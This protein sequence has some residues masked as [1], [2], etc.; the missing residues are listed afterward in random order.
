MV[1][2]PFVNESFGN[3]SGVWPFCDLSCVEGQ[4][5]KIRRNSPTTFIVFAISISL[6]AAALSSKDAKVAY[7]QGDYATAL[8]IWSS[9]A[10]QASAEAQERLGA[11]YRDGKGVSQDY[12]ASVEWFRKAADQGDGKAENNLGA[13]YARGHGVAKNDAQAVNWFRKAADHGNALGQTNLGRMYT[14]GR[15][16]PKDDAESVEWFRLAAEQG[17][18]AA[19]TNRAWMYA[20]G[21]GV[22][23]DENEAV[24]WYRKAAE[25]GFASAQDNLG[26]MYRDGRSVTQ[27]FAV[28]VE[29]FRKAAEQGYAEGE[30]NLGYMYS[31]G[32]GVA[33]DYAEAMKWYRKAAD[34]GE[35]HAQTNLGYMYA[36]GHG[37]SKDDAEAVLW[38]RKAAEQG[39]ARAQ[40][41]LAYMYLQ[42]HG[43]PK[44]EAEA[45]SLYRKAAEQGLPQ[46]QNGLGVMYRDGRGL[47]QDYVAAIEWFR[48]AGEQG[49]ASAQINLGLMYRD[50]Q[51]VTKDDAAATQWLQKAAEQGDKR[52]KSMLTSIETRGQDSANLGSIVAELVK[53]YEDGQPQVLNPDAERVA[54]ASQLIDALE[55]RKRLANLPEGFDQVDSPARIAKVSPKLIEAIRLTAV[56]SFRPEKLVKSLDKKLAQTLDTPTLQ[57]GLDWERSDLGRRINALELEAERLEHRAAKKEFVQQ[58][59][60]K[61]RAADDARGRACGEKLIL[62][63]SP[64]ALLP[65][66]EALAAAGAMAIA[67]QQEQP[68]DMRGIEGAMLIVRPTL[69]DVAR[70]AM[71]AE[72][73]FSLQDLS[74]AEF[75]RLLGFLHTESGGRYARGANAAQ[76]D[77]F[78]DATEVFARTL[79]DVARKLRANR[80]S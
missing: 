65:L 64:D 19:Q 63:N 15:G 66:M 33:Q 76:R 47:A 5:M 13:M 17:D 6:G 8:R 35:A 30:N 26:V 53:K 7:D 61:G 50:G 80:E 18:A 24:L 28:A 10:E 37:V 51:G 72:C 75:E 27:D 29:L 68:L 73:L 40:T 11:L 58:F 23:R 52:A 74:D 44:D 12:V 22:P 16:V 67:V 45:A 42:G 39:H 1:G 4:S 79:I 55:F 9:L 54:L 25:Q 56:A 21:G 14:Q 2:P 78:L 3:E 36:Q 48:K 46:A 34:Q 70:Q 38:Y 49:D 41:N 32:R 77:A 20:G 57:A 60:A 69:R 43:V 62:D 59:V 31:T 71:L